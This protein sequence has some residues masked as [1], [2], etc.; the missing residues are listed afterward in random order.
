MRQLHKRPSSASR[1]C[2]GPQPAGHATPCCLTDLHLQTTQ[3]NVGLCYCSTSQP[4][5]RRRVI[6]IRA[7]CLQVSAAAAACSLRVFLTCRW[8]LES[9][10]RQKKRHC[11]RLSPQGQGCGNEQDLLPW[12]CAKFEPNTSA[13][14]L[15]RTR[16]VLLLAASTI[17]S[18]VQSWRRLQLACGT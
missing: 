11:W 10:R 1:R 14:A 16:K 6:C 9:K 4:M 12:A 8:P 15:R 3:R 7:R 2:C 17:L 5:G 18:G 13:T